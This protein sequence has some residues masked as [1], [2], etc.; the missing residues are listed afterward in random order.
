MK[1]KIIAFTA[2][3]WFA[4]SF[5]VSA[6]KNPARFFFLPA[7]VTVEGAEIP[8]GMYQLT[9]ESSNSSVRIIWWREGQFV[10]SASGAWVKSGM[11]YSEN[12]V[13]LRVNSD[14]SRSLV[15]IRLAGSTRAIVLK[16]TD[17]IIRYSEK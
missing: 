3:I 9:V 7:P 13:L 11:K 16:N 15:E 8:Q 14:G 5:P 1:L 2:W 10:A 6:R 12:T 4:A 17:P